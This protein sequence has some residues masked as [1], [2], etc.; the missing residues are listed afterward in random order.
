MAY[1]DDL[2]LISRKFE[3]FDIPKEKR[4]LLKY[5]DTEIQEAFLRYFLVFGTY[6]SFVDHTGLLCQ[7]RYRRTLVNKFYL[8]EKLHKEAKNN[9]DMTTLARIEAGKYKFKLPPEDYIT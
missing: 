4:Y 6:E 1:A 7:V 2:N 5:F 9:M 8:L 3:S